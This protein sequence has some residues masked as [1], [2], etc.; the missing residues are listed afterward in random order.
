MVAAEKTV[1]VEPGSE[2]ARI[3]D[4]AGDR[5]LI[6]VKS[7]VRYRVARESSIEEAKAGDPWADYDPEKLMEGVLAVAGSIT[8]EEAERMKAFIYAAREA[9]TRPPD[10]L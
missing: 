10:R 2:L 3:L 4:E 8:V 5:S 1:N 7:G 6:L 9:G